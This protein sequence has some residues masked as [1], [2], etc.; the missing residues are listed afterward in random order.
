[1]VALHHAGQ[2]GEAR[3]LAGDLLAEADRRGARGVARG[4]RELF[5]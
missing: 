4:L 1:V 5:P 2:E 3:R